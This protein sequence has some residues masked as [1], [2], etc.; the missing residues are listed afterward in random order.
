M[1]KYA[2]L[3]LLALVLLAACSAAGP[4]DTADRAIR[5]CGQGNVAYVDADDGQFACK[6]EPYFFDHDND[7]G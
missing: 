5:T 7:N 3:A 2:V 4:E 1:T 6:P